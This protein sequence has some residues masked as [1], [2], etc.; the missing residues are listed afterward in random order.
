MTR[1][2]LAALAALVL[3]LGAC[4]GDGPQGPADPTPLT[5]A[6]SREIETAAGDEAEESL[7]ALF[8]TD[9]DDPFGLAGADAGFAASAACPDRSPR[10]PEN[11][12]GDGV[13]TAL[14][15]TFDPASCT[16]TRQ[17]GASATLFGVRRVSDPAPGVAGLDRDVVLEGLGFELRRGDTALRVTRD[18]TRAVRGTAGSLRAT[19]DVTVARV[20]TPGGA[21]SV[22]KR[23]EAEFTP[24]GGE[25]LT[26][27]RP[28]PSGTLTLAGTLAWEGTERDAVLTLSTVTP[29]HYDA[30]CADGRPA[31]RFDAGELRYA[32]TVD[33]RSRGYLTVR[34]VGC[35]RAPEREWTAAE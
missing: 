32:R 24:D 23:G 10:I 20:L 19:E 28:R 7:A 18:G 6:Q 1:N 16:R 12:D 27:G 21:T 17:D 15:I 4:G 22:R 33:G 2:T 3:T 5:D 35:G 29:L 14:T 8:E 11:P 9:L 30:T 26:P 25:P 34:F 13:P 31:R